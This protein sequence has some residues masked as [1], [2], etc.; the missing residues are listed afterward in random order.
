MKRVLLA[1]VLAVGSLAPAKAASQADFMQTETPATLQGERILLAQ[2][3]TWQAQSTK[4][5]PAN[6]Y[7][8]PGYRPRPPGY[9]PPGYRP[10]PGYRPPG[11]RPPAAAYRPPGGYRPRPGYRPY[12]GWRPAYPGWRPGWAPS[13]WYGSYWRP[14]YGWAVAA[15][16]VAV[17]VLAATA[18]TAYSV[19]PPPNPA[20]CWFY[21]DQTFQVGYWAPCP[22]PP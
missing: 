17:G 18:A 12:P 13:P 1:M 15:G 10:G 14:G 2:N 4:R 19:P 11:Y 9:R 21:T 22:P 20:Y 7:Q 5:R 3:G 6:T 16:I 8:R